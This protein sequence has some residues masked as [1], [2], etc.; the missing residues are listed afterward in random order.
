MKTVRLAIIGLLLLTG[1]G[2][3]AG[4]DAEQQK[5]LARRAAIA[6]AYRK[7]AEMVYGVQINSQTLVRD[8]VTE[9]DEIRSDVDAMVRG[10]RVGEARYYPDGSCDIE[11]EVTVAK[12]ITTLQTA[13]SRYYKGDSVKSSDF[14][15]IS[16]RIDKKVLKVVGSGAPREDLP[17]GLPMGVMEDLGGP[18]P[19]AMPFIP[20]IWAQ[21][22]AQARLMA[23]RG[24]TLDAMRMLAERIKGVRLTSRTLVRDFVTE[25][26]EIMTELQA[27]LHGFEYAREYYHDNEL[28][29]EV[30]LRVPTEQVVTMIRELHTRHYKGDDVKG[31]DIDKVTRSVIKRD[32][33]ATGMS[34]AP[35]KYM[36]MRASTP[37][38]VT[39]IFPPPPDWVSGVI[40]AQ[41][42]GTD[43][44]FGTAQGRLKA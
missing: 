26:D 37:P 2:I 23:K 40:R 31:M 25:S 35:R 21:Y 10:I 12:V 19:G 1:V 4:Q 20:P 3:A 11:A 8:F 32:F 15:S 29:A 27:N 14:E 30:T 44:D 9:S 39:C 41:G 13:H 43:P 18:P 17:P 22:P 34:V 28:I 7:L 16:E 33:E 36:Q 24:A 6:D 42:E 38:T 5:L